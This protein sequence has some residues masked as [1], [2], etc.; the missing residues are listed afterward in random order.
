MEP[1][2]SA[3]GRGDS[4]AR[5]ADA[6]S[7]SEI[8]KKIADRINQKMKEHLRT[9]SEVGLRAAIVHAVSEKD[10]ESMAE[11]LLSRKNISTK[12]LKTIVEYVES[13]RDE[14]NAKLRTRDETHYG[15]DS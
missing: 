5:L 14:A 2:G 4:E 3:E 13:K 10:R 6:Q 12:S 7:F 1:Q 11:E 15:A 8:D 9:M